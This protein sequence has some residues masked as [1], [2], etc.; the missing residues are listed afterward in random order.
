MEKAKARKSPAD[1]MQT[2]AYMIGN[3][4]DYSKSVAVE[5][6]IS[7]YVTRTSRTVISP[8]LPFPV[9]TLRTSAHKLPGS[10]SRIPT[11]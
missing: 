1:L 7:L 5:A 11:V 4:L 3:G 6:D 8:L 9:L 10:L 2:Y